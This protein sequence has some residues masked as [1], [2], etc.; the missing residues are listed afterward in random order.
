MRRHLTTALLFA[1]VTLGFAALAATLLPTAAERPAVVELA[2]AL[3]STAAE[4][5]PFLVA[6]LGDG[7]HLDA[8]QVEELTAAAD[9][10]CEGVTADVPVMVM[11]DTLAGELSLTDEEARHLVN[12]AA[13][14]HCAPAAA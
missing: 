12:T 5:S 1:A 9:R 8:A 13:T 2:P 11:A 10:V 6:L 14:V 3:R 4:P 7:T